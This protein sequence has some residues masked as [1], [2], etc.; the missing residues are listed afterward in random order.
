VFLQNVFSLNYFHKFLLCGSLGNSLSTGR[1]AGKG[2]VAYNWI[3][4]DRAKA[5]PTLG[6]GGGSVIVD[7]DDEKDD[8][9]LA[10]AL[11]QSLQQHQLHHDQQMFRAS[12]DRFYNEGAMG[13]KICQHVVRKGCHYYV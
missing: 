4:P 11:Y 13:I 3:S 12:K 7:E 2:K 6:G 10:F 1:N 5:E 8:D 9:Q